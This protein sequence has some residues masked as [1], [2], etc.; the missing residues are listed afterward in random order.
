MHAG[1]PC[2]LGD[3][4]RVLFDN[5]HHQIAGAVDWIIDVTGRHPYPSK[6]QNETDWHGSLSAWA[7]DLPDTGDFGANRARRRRNRFV[8]R[9]SVRN[10]RRRESHAD[11]HHIKRQQKLC[12]RRAIRQ[13]THRC[14]RRFVDCRRRQRISWDSAFPKP[15][16]IQKTTGYFC[17]MRCNGCAD[18]NNIYTS[19]NI[20]IKARRMLAARPGE[21]IA[22]QV[23]RIA[24]GN[25]ATGLPYLQPAGRRAQK[26][27]LRRRI[28]AAPQ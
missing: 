26:G 24:K 11:S 8:C 15:V 25:S 28:A 14:R 1:S 5:A 23:A 20:Y 7:K 16:I 17:S 10:R 19:I 6:P 27:R 2:D 12:R 21:N 22:A 18:C 9:N 4:P 3:R 13:R